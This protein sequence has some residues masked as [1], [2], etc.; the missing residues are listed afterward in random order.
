M[1]IKS[2]AVYG[3]GGFG[4]EIRGMLEMQ[5]HG[6]GF[7]GY[8]DDFKNLEQG[9]LAIDYDDVLIAIASPKIRQH[10]VQN[11]RFHEVA[12]MKLI[13]T[14]VSIHNSVQV[15]K[16]SIICSG[17]RLTV[18]I[19]IG[20]FV[21]INLN[22]TIGHDVVIRDYCSIM[23]SVNISGNVVLHKGVFVGTGATILQGITI[24]ENAVI[25][26]GAVITKDVPP[27]VTVMGVPGKIDIR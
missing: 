26:A 27:N 6:L 24:G 11:W 4:K 25:G 9:L 19:T 20:E 16:G 8:I 5:F 21:I 7:A 22:A 15:G 1:I 13:S 3:A 18:D 17:A 12:F 23:P 14:D 2:I 10:L